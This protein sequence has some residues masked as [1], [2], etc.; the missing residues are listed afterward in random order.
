MKLSDIVY[1]LLTS[2][3]FKRLWKVL[4]QQIYF[5]GKSRLLLCRS[6]RVMSL[7]NIMLYYTVSW[8]ALGT[9][10]LSR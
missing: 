9:T 8:A 6:G 2:F 5:R 4:K 7:D 1:V 3:I 10:K